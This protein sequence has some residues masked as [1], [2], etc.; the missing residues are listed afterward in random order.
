M[1][2]ILEPTSPMFGYI[3]ADFSA[4]DCFTLGYV[5]SIDAELKITIDP[6]VAF[7]TPT[8]QLSCTLKGKY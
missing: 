5:K 8:S 7:P 1:Y 2:N 4:S 6:A 3:F